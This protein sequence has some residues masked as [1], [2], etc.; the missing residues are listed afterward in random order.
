MTPVRLFL[1]IYSSN[2]LM[3]DL[4]E[5]P[6]ST[7]LRIL[8]I[9]EITNF[10]PPG[11][12]KYAQKRTRAKLDEAVAKLSP[13]QQETL[14]AFAREKEKKTRLP[15]VEEMV[16]HLSREQQDSL[17]DFVRCKK[18]KTCAAP[19]EGCSPNEHTV[20][21]SHDLFLE[22]VSEECR[23]ERLIKFIDATNRNAIETFVCAVCAGRFFGR[24]TRPVKL[25]DL[26]EKGKLYPAVT[27][28]AHE[29]TDG[30]LLHRARNH[31]T[32]TN[33]TH[34]SRAYLSP[35]SMPCARTKRPRYPS[36]TICG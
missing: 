11:T 9:N 19:P 21:S 4:N 12:F 5:S 35:A 13:E 1:L 25:S 26:K 30:M 24:D 14:L 33:T 16:Q 27:N 31:C 7:G 3:D 29:L 20:D 2:A 23:R 34:V 32:R 10:F 18:R 36:L 15:S 17:L 28:S 6:L 8:T 22:T